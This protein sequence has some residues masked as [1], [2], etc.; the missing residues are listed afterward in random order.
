[1]IRN[2]PAR[3]AFWTEF[4]RQVD[5]PQGDERTV[6]DLHDF[7]DFPQSE[8]ARLLN[9]SPKRVSRLGLAATARLAGHLDGSDEMAT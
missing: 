6:F 3:L 5:S 4:H 8:I 2:G 9:L 1:L 7:G